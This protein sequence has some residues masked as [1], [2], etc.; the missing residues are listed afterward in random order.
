MMII[1]CVI[2]VSHVLTFSD[3]IVDDED[4]VAQGYLSGSFPVL[5]LSSTTRT[6]VGTAYDHTR[7]DNGESYVHIPVLL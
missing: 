6:T 5:V 1:K 2:Y 7:S 4:L 3:F